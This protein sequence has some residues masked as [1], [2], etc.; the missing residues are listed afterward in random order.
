MDVR[1]GG[2]SHGFGGGWGATGPGTSYV[3]VANHTTQPHQQLDEMKFNS[4]YPVGG[5]VTGKGSNFPLTNHRS[6]ITLLP[7]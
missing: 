4:L 5:L 2:F 3:G 1:V 7:R 6:F